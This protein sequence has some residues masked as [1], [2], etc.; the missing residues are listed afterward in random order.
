M[1]YIRLA[2]H[3]LEVVSIWRFMCF[4]G[5]NLHVRLKYAR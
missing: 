1:L 3:S 4:T 5:V 2:P